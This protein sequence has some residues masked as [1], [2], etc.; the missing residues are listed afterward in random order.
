[1]TNL[2]PKT[3]G[4]G[5][6]PA[7]LLVPSNPAPPRPSEIPPAPRAELCRLCGGIR[8]VRPWEHPSCSGCGGREFYPM[9]EDP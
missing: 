6:F 3:P 1:M 2:G 5:G 8:H 7:P 9:P 4:F